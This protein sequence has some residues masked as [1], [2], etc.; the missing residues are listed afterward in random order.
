M[1]APLRRHLAPLLGLMLVATTLSVAA[2]T[3]PRTTDDQLELAG[4]IGYCAYP[5]NAGKVFRWG[6][7]KW[8]YEFETGAFPRKVWKSTHP[9]QIGQQHGMLTIFANKGQRKVRTWGTMKAAKYGRWEA[10]MRAVELAKTGKHFRFIWRLAP[11]NGTR[12]NS[13][14]ITLAS[15]RPGDKRVRGAVRTRPSHSFSYAQGRDLRSR[16]WHAFA[17]EV[18]PTHI[19]WFVDTRVV[20]TER[21]PAA[22]AGYKLRPEFIIKGKKGETMR[23]SMLQMDWVRHYTL[24]RKNAKSIKAPRMNKGTYTKGC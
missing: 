3:S 1:F 24:E 19:S 6:H 2:W 12:C 15:F 9:K 4:C 14:V 17:V 23:R 21:R 8:R 11:V 18:T 22:L 13:K 5:R 16:A 7:E 10:R 20:H